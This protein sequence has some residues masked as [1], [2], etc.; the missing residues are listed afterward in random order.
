MGDAF[1]PPVTLMNAA[2][3]ELFEQGHPKEDAPEFEAWKERVIEMVSHLNYDQ[4]G[5]FANY[6]A[7]EAKLNDR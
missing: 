3:K 6:L 1:F 2:A 4:I 5:N 7:F